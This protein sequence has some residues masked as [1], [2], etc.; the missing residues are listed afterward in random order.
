[1][2]A[3]RERLMPPGVTGSMRELLEKWLELQRETLAHKC[4]G[5]DDAR[6]R[7]AAV[8][9]SDLS[10][11]GLVKHLT[12]VERHWFRRVLSG[13]DAPPRYY[14]D[15]DPDGD[16]RVGAEES[17]EALFATWREEIAVARERA[18]ERELAD[19]GRHHGRPVDLA[20]IYT[21][22]I[23]EYARHL[24]H[25]DLLRERLDGTTGY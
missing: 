25:A 2:T 1:M 11:L 12:D 24:G 13:E 16:F 14:T 21:H 7:E 4:A 5:L 6:L 19:T 9:P 17:A 3:P 15:D 23:E 20:W 10:L 18:A 8:P 22:M